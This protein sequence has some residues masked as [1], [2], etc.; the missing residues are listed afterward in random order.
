M[1]CSKLEAM[2]IYV[3]KQACDNDI[4]ASEDH[5]PVLTVPIGNISLM[6]LLRDSASV[7]NKR[8]TNVAE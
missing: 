2:A 1:A 4:M 6:F 5:A 3:V 7:S 8:P